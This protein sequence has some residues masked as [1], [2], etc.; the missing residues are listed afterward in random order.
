[1]GVLPFVG[2]LSN[3]VLSNRVDLTGHCGTNLC[4]FDLRD[5]TNKIVFL[6][7]MKFLDFMEYLRFLKIVL[8]D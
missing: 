4:C 5:L 3:A 2:F 6:Q 7:I 1:M 8:P